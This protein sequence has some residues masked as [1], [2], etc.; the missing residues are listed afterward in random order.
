MQRII[1]VLVLVLSLV[2]SGCGS[3]QV[4]DPTVTP[5]QISSTTPIP[6]KTP[7]PI[8]TSTPVHFSGLDLSALNVQVADLWVGFQLA[9]QSNTGSGPFYEAHKNN[10]TN[11]HFSNYTS[12]SKYNGVNYTSYFISYLY[13]FTNGS[14]AKQA[15]TYPATP[16]TTSYAL[17]DAY[18][19]E[20]PVT[21]GGIRIH[22]SWIYHEV[23]GDI[24]Y[25]GKPLGTDAEN[26]KM[27]VDVAQ[28]IQARLEASQ[29]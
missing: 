15:F 26:I 29:R 17:G 6:T 20:V 19:V 16:P 7:T 5:T 4:A 2:L 28:A 10:I 1:V 18:N 13:V 9:T 12:S 25:L 27:V 22:V 8:P 3:G 24:N 23:I 11:F 14:L 21:P